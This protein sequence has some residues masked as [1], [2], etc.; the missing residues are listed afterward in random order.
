[1][2]KLSEVRPLPYLV[3][4]IT[5]NEEPGSQ[6]LTPTR[7]NPGKEVVTG[8]NG[9]FLGFFKLLTWTS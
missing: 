8:I 7:E 2:N 6:V 3:R 4:S 9:P 5:W 1:M